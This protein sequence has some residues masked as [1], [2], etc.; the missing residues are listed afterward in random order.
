MIETKPRINRGNRGQH[1]RSR[2]LAVISSIFMYF[3]FRLKFEIEKD[4]IKTKQ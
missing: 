2:S 3:E 1:F 4:F